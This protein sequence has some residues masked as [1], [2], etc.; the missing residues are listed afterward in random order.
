MNSRRII[1]V[2]ALIIGLGLCG[3]GLM[4]LLMPAYYEGMAEIEIVQDWGSNDSHDTDA[5]RIHF[6]EKELKTMQSEIV[7]SNAVQA[8]NLNIKWG[9]LY[10]RDGVLQTANAIK[11]LQRHIFAKPDPKTHLVEIY[12]IDESPDEAA[13]I[14]NAVVDAYHNYCVEQNREEESRKIQKLEE[15]YQ[16]EAAEIAN[17][18]TNVDEQA[19]G[20]LEEKLKAHQKL[21]KEIDEEK[22]IIPKSVQAVEISP[23]EPPQTPS[24]PN[25]LEGA[26]LLSGGLVLSCFGI[27]SLRGGNIKRR[28]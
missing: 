17:L 4:L 5:S 6:L 20:D 9:K 8:L 3:K 26:G 18:Q 11:I 14:A 7:L 23:A 16:K 15:D 24:G 21:R 28:K 22:D 10:G 13:A 2:V 12:A 27:F 1:G 25:R 19:K